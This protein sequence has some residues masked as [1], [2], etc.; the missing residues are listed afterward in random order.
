MV[1]LGHFH[2]WAVHGMPMVA[3]AE[4]HSFL[5]YMGG[6]RR[7]G[8]HRGGGAGGGTVG[9]RGGGWRG[10]QDQGMGREVV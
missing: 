4:A 9:A 7:R 3:H 1:A 2:A 8:G 6:K 10:D 5:P